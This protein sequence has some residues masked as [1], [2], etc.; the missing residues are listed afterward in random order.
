MTDAE[1]LINIADAILHPHE[2]L[3]IA[4]GGPSYTVDLVALALRL[5]SKPG[6]ALKAMIEEWGRERI[7]RELY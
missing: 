3:I 2:R 7:V 5:H 1:R 6:I 4:D